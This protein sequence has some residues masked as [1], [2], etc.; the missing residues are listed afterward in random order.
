MVSDAER[1]AR[2]IHK[3]DVATAALAAKKEAADAALDA[4]WL[5]CLACDQHLKAAHAAEVERAKNRTP[6][7]PAMVS[8][9]QCWR[10]R[11]AHACT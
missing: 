6:T 4:A 8:V 7:G 1:K 2:K 5:A 10:Q 3:A 11:R 9:P